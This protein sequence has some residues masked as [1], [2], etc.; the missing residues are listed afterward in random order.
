MIGFTYVR[1][2]LQAPLAALGLWFAFLATTGDAW[3]QN[4]LVKTTVA[5]REVDGHRVL[6]DVYRPAGE[7]VRPVIVWIHGGALIMGHR[8]GIHRSVRQLAEQK[9]YALVSIDYRLAP[10]TKLPELISDVESAFKWIGGEGGERFH[11]D[12]DRIAVCGGSAGGYLT[13]VTG[14]RA[15]P[16][17]KALV[18]LYGY[19]SL[20]SEWYAAP[21]PHPRHNQRKVTTDEADRQ[22]D[23]TVVSDSRRRKGNGS[24]IYLHY[25]QQG[26]WAS[27]VSGFSPDSITEEIRAY[28]PLRHVGKDYPPTLLIHGTKDTD[29]PF[30]ESQR[31]ADRLKQANV[32]V[33]LKPIVN[34]EHGFGGGDRKQIEEAFDFMRQF[35]VKHLEE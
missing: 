12:A 4:S 5:Y 30:E 15:S 7:D 34:G 11:L 2:S 27:K 28:E 3:A 25:R 20:T 33:T 18:A 19:G 1:N 29:V 8:E 32:P 13:L 21:S 10:E 35:L 22:S 17:P 14:F 24:L 31:M 26:I 6:A 9:G 23:G 16:K